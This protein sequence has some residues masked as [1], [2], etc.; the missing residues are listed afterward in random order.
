MTARLTEVHRELMGRLRTRAAVG[1]GSAWDALAADTSS[2]DEYVGLVVPLVTAAQL[3]AVA[4]TDAYVSKAAGRPPIGITL[5]ELEARLRG[6]DL[7]TVYERPFHTTWT[8]LSNGK[9][10]ADAVAAG[11]ARAVTAAATDVSLAMRATFAVAGAALA[12]VER[13]V[14][15]GGGCELCASAEGGIYAD[16]GDMELHPNCGCS[17]EPV[18]EESSTFNA[19]GSPQSFEDTDTVVH[20]HGELGPML[21]NRGDEFRDEE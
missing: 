10:A 2:P 13:F 1:A 8:A 21:A 19:E 16:A 3:Q 20:D 14:R 11:R 15:V 12:N 4:L 9:D 5:A 6:V 18:V 17:L 7:D